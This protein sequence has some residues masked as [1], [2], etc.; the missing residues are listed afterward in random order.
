MIRN[1]REK[2]A[3]GKSFFTQYNCRREKCT[4]SFITGSPTF[5]AAPTK[6]FEVAENG[7]LQITTDFDGNPEPTAEVEFPPSSTKSAMTVT[8]LYPFI[9]RATYTLKRVPASY[10][11][12]TVIIRVKNEIGT[13]TET[14][15]I[16]VI[17]KFNLYPLF[18]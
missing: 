5:V 8:K 18:P 6:S 11:G 13:I 4:S 3:R 2:A 16:N 14:S 9:F 1:L 15:T 17:C 10:C 7:E 12:R